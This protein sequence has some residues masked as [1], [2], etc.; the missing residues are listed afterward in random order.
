MN[1]NDCKEEFQRNVHIIM[2][3]IMIMTNG[4]VHGAHRVASWNWDCY[5]FWSWLCSDSGYLHWAMQVGVVGFC[6]K[7]RSMIVYSKVD[8]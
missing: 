3:M 7:T 6:R 2:K 1:G 5:C 4:N 8:C